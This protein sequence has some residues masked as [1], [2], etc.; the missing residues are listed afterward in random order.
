MLSVSDKYYSVNECTQEV[1]ELMKLRVWQ[2]THKFIRQ[3]AHGMT[4]LTDRAAED[5]TEWE[6]LD[7][8]MD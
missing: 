4:A 1:S 3:L 2:N 5:G 7:D 8:Q 6:A